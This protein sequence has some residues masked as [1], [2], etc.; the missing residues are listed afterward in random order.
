[1]TKR[2]FLLFLAILLVSCSGE[3]SVLQ[4]T[5]K[6]ETPVSTQLRPPAYLPSPG[7]PGEFQPIACRFALPESIVEG[8]DVECGFLTVEEHREIDSSQRAR[9]IRLAVAIFH[10]PGGATQPDPVIY[11]SGGPGAS[12]L[13]LIRYQYDLMSLPVF[14]TG[15][16][17]VM[18]DQRGVGLSQPAL[19]CPMFDELSLELLDRQVDGRQVDDQEISNL[20][21]RTLETC[22]EELSEVADLSSYNSSASA[23]DV[24]DLRRALGYQQVNLWGGSYGTRLALEVM[25]SYPEGLRSVVLDAVYPPDVDLYL[26]A[27]VNF[28]RA[29]ERLFEACAG[30][31]VCS[32]AYPDLRGVFFET[33]ARLDAEPVL[34]EVVNPFTG[35]EYDAWMNGNT[36]LALTFQLLYDSKIRY[37]IPQFIYAASQGDY[38]AFERVRGNLMGLMGVSSRGMMFSVQCH[39]EL[40][41]SSPGEFRRMMERYP[42]L[43]AM[44]ESALLG[45]LAYQACESWG[46]GRAEE[47]ANRPV[48]SDIPTLIM[49]GEFDPITPPAWGL[50]AAETLSK[51][52]VY[53]YP[54]IGHGASAVEGCPSQMMVAFLENPDVAPS[55]NCISEMMR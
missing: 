49:N 35:E 47:N 48:S 44:Y 21:L 14:N 40:A 9:F 42:E 1:M 7:A 53:E 2:M 6:A 5:P 31:S 28:N 30:N 20:F 41:F 10:P 32:Q 39:E 45:G 16:D 8:E 11:L 54:G 24:N 4:S 46:A 19:D 18:F 12:A 3:D 33:V 38:T 15:R 23:A 17:L 55:G 52:F 13:E 25:R 36:L 43:G 27:P 51:S 22:Q 26:E 29:L 50:H 37:L 34:T